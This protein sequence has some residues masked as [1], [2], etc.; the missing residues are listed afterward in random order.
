[1]DVPVRDAIGKKLFLELQGTE[2]LIL[3]SGLYYKRASRIA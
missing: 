3:V 1:L 2:R